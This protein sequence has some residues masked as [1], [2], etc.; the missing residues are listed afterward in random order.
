MEWIRHTNMD[1]ASFAPAFALYEQSF[2]LHE[3]RFAAHQAQ[4]MGDPRFFC[5]SVWE[6]GELLAL[7]FSWR[8]E[9]I[10]YVEHYAVN[11]S[12]RGGGLGSQILREFCQR[13]GKVVLEIDPL[14]DEISR[15]RKGFYERLGFCA[16]PWPHAHPP[17]RKANAP[18]E[19]IVMSWP[20]ELSRE[21][22]D[23]FYRALAREVM[24]YAEH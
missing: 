1:E 5:E 24:A 19:L 23:R 21:E 8:L 10:C 22:Y 9:D 15:R 18:H 17:Y 16:N 6:N 4:A 13:E 20:R 2:P 11:S 12:L 14:V 3:Q 7:L